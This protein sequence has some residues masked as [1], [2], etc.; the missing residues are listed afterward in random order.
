MILIIQ[1]SRLIL[2]LLRIGK[3]QRNDCMFDPVLIGKIDK[4]MK[5]TDHL[6]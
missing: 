3:L 5:K 4:N 2:Q 6:G 1:T